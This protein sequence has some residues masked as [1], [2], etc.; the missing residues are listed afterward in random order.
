MY[1]ELW[2]YRSRGSDPLAGGSRIFLFVLSLLP[3]NSPRCS[4]QVIGQILLARVLYTVKS[5]T[6][7]MTIELGRKRSWN[8][9]KLRTSL[10]F[11]SLGFLFLSKNAAGGKPRTRFLENC[12]NSTACENITKFFSW[13]NL[14]RLSFHRLIEFGTLL[15]SSSFCNI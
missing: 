6:V 12:Q 14:P 13:L 10:Y 3:R 11:D 1:R 15:A 7:S 8:D 9:T 2:H 4:E 5:V